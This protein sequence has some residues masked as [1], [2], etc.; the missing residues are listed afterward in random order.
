MRTIG[1]AE[2]VEPLVL[3]ID[4]GSSSVRALLYDSGGDQVE[5]SERQLGYTQHMTPDGG[6]ESDPG[7]ILDLVVR[8]VDGVVN[9]PNHRDAQIAAVGMTSFWH[10]LM[11]LD[12]SG[13]PCTPIY[14]WSDKRSGDDAL[15]LADELDTRSVH[16]RTGCRIHSSYWPAK[17]RWLRRSDPDRHARV[18]TWLSITDYLHREFFGPLATSI[19][20]ASG[21][22]LLDGASLGWDNEML[23]T[24][25]LNASNLPELRDRTDAYTGLR[26]PFAGRWPVLAAIPWYPAIGD[27]AAA[28]VGAGCVGDSLLA[29]TVGTS[30]AMRLIVPDSNGHER[31]ALPHRIWRYRL[32]RTYQVLGGALSNGG[33]VTNWL[34]SHLALG[35]FDELTEAAARIQPDG[36]GLTILPFLAGERS[37]S[38]NEH[39]TGTISGIRLS[40]TSGDLFRATLEATAYRMAA[41]YDDLRL[42]AAPEHEIHANGGAVLSSPLWLQIIADTLDH[43][44][45]AVDAEAEASARGA[46]ICALESL[47]VVDSLC[48]FVN[49]VS[50]RYHPDAPANA[51]YRSARD[52]QSALEAALM[53]L[54]GLRERTYHT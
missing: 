6:S 40:T 15:S 17:L 49:T 9:D 13:E 38:W 11:G 31:Q 45:D 20:M 43:R 24:L 2:A 3:A 7:A 53:T 10:G 54:P 1:I 30:A 50:A 19:S 47:G 25:E 41:I 21:T 42:L 34:A 12:R 22:G 51:R 48:D 29:M 27:G 26:D 33:N 18:R 44:L 28:N 39:A 16:Q 52:R 36:H 35:E 4:V 46:A 23:A 5:S 14:M 37:P 8:C 32:D